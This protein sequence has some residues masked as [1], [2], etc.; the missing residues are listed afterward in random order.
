MLFRVSGVIKRGEKHHSPATKD[1]LNSLSAFFHHS[2]GVPLIK[3]VWEKLSYQGGTASYLLE[4]LSLTP[5]FRSQL[6]WD[7]PYALRDGIIYAQMGRG[8]PS[9]CPL[10]GKIQKFGISKLI[11]MRSKMYLK[12][13]AQE[14]KISE[15]CLSGLI[16]AIEKNGYVVT[17][18]PRNT[19]IPIR[20]LNPMISLDAYYLGVMWGGIEREYSDIG[21][22]IISPYVKA[23][24]LMNEYLLLDGYVIKIAGSNS[25]QLLVSKHSGRYRINQYAEIFGIPVNKHLEEKTP[26]KSDINFLGFFRGW[27]ECRGWWIGG[28]SKRK[29]GTYAERRGLC[30]AGSKKILE[31]LAKRIHSE[32]GASF[33]PPRDQAPNRKETKTFIV[34]YAIKD[35][36]IIFEALSAL[37]VGDPLFIES[38]L[39]KWGM[40]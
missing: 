25:C 38:A 18:P 6:V 8:F 37:K 12:K 23:L 3:P 32:L 34:D 2:Y 19:G 26:P 24:E 11:E 20:E 31:Y 36:G 15:T 29:N 13:M 40:E 1:F 7:G 4:R 16:K 28:R 30:L 39:K 9:L 33:R 5:S 10:E 17:T 14:L 21:F 22:K 27:A 35:S